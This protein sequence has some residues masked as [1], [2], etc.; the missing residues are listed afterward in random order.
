MVEVASQRPARVGPFDIVGVLGQGGMGVIYSAQLPGSSHRVAVK[1]VPVAD[2]SLL[3]SMRREIHALG[4]L[5]HPGVVRVLDSGFDGG[6]PWYA[7]ELL[8]GPTLAALRDSLWGIDEPTG[9]HLSLPG[10]RVAIAARPRDERTIH[11]PAERP[12][13][14]RGKL[15]RVLTVMRRLLGTLAFVHGEGIVHRDI[16][17]QNVFL[18]DGDQPVLFDFGMATRSAGI[19]GREVVDV[20]LAIG[21]APAYMAPEQ[22]CGNLVDSRADL[23]AAGCVFYELLTGRPPFLG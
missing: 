4:R 23:Y 18:R 21:G 1:T 6:R 2:E 20:V 13:I 14:D 8:E 16:K 3:S 9:R 7:M 17:P 19:M 10:R 5:V 22:I 15:D 12:A 11:A